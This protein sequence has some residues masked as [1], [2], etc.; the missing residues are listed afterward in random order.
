MQAPKV[1]KNVQYSKKNRKMNLNGNEGKSNIG[2]DGQSSSTCSSD[3]DNVFQDTNGVATSD[4][5]ASQAL[6]LNGKTK[7]SR[8]SATDPQ[9]LYAR[10]RNLLPPYPSC[11]DSIDRTRYI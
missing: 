2:S 1:H 4:S 10:V 5:K 3:D 7:A 8:G 11:H 6:N 9:S